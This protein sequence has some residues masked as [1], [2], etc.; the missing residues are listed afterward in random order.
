MIKKFL[1]IAFILNVGT[2]A[3]KAQ[4]DPSQAAAKVTTKDAMT[5]NRNSITVIP[6]SGM[7]QYD[8][9]VSNW[10]KGQDFDGKFDYNHIDYP[11]IGR[12]IN[13][14]SKNNLDS[15]KQILLNYAVPKKVSDYWVQ[16]DG[17][18]F[19]TGVFEERAIY[20]KT[21]ADVLKEQASKVSTSLFDLGKELM[22]NSFLLVA[23]PTVVSSST[24]KKGITTYSASS[25]GFVYHVDLNDE[26]L[27]TISQNWLD[28]EA[29]PNMKKNYDDVVIGLESTATVSG[30]SGEG[31]TP[32]EAITNSLNALFE[33][34]EKKVDKWQVVTSVYR[35]HPIG[36]KIGTK[37]GLKNS[38]RYTIFRLTEDM[39]GNL[40]YKKVGYARAT[41]IAENKGI[42]EGNSPCSDFY[43]ISGRRNAKEGMFLK[44]N[45]D[46]KLN[47]WVSG[48]F[49]KNALAPVNVDVDYLIKTSQTLGLM[50]YSGISIGANFGKQK[51]D[52]KT[53]FWLPVSL[54]YGL[55]IHFLRWLELTPNVGVGAMMPLNAAEDSNNGDDVSFAKKI[56]YYAHGGVKLGFQVCYPVS[57]FIRADYSYDFAHGEWW[58]FYEPKNKPFGFSLGAGVKINF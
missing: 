18:L 1:F 55:G 41:R 58:E 39:D 42:A 19:K 56:A 25:T 27:E 22:K 21:D 53:G 14:K 43:Q 35:L 7:T 51:W 5:Y 31:K 36:A 26:V 9:F 23:G 50:Q 57:I 54:H 45:K 10:A 29:T 3:I 17:K 20:N 13:P 34:L 11:Q 47:L 49:L 4:D 46:T 32:E 38:D 2:V 37:E 8:A 12:I 16:Y 28:E 24:N 40:N 30:A 48:N 6:I 52:D 15:I 33:K 44:Q